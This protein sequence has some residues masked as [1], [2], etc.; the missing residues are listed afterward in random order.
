MNE[1]K[2]HQSQGGNF[3]GWEPVWKFKKV[4]GEEYL[5]RWRPLH[6]TRHPDP[7]DPT[8]TEIVDPIMHGGLLKTMGYC[9]FAQARAFAYS[10]LA[11]HEGTPGKKDDIIIGIRE[12]DIIYDLKSYIRDTIDLIEMEDQYINLKEAITRPKGTSC[13]ALRATGAQGETGEV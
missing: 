9:G 6:I 2:I 11:L 4:T 7:G 3:T 10:W 8:G 1:R 13:R 12:L 5:D